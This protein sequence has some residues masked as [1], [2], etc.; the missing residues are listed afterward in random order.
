MISS[1]TGAAPLTPLTFHMEAPEKLPIQTPTVYR[2]EYPTH[3]LSR[4]SLLVPVLTAVQKRVASGFSRP[5]VSARLSRSDRMSDTR[6]A[7]PLLKTLPSFDRGV[8]GVRRDAV[9]TPPLA[10]DR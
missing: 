3:Q 2:S 4:M 9:R 8:S 7:A 6:K 1:H 10:I 5:N